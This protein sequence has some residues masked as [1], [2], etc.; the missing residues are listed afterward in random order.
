MGYPEVVSSEANYLKVEPLWAL[1]T[2]LEDFLIWNKELLRVVTKK[3]NLKQEYPKEKTVWPITLYLRPIY[4]KS[5]LWES[6][7]ES[8][9]TITSDI[10]L[11]EDECFK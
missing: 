1:Y 11:I 6:I 9:F 3:K 4:S 10:T 2:K 7:F 5:K 8:S